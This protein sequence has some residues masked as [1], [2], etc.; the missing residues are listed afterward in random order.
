MQAHKDRASQWRER[1]DS[2]RD[3]REECLAHATDGQVHEAGINKSKKK[4]PNHHHHLVCKTGQ[5]GEKNG[6]KYGHVH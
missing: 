2:Q 6:G 1:L 5:K 3:T 4:A